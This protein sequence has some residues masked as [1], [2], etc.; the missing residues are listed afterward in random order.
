MIEEHGIRTFHG[1]R[2]WAGLLVSFAFI[3]LLGWGLIQAMQAYLARL[4]QIARLSPDTAIARAGLSMQILGVVM[5]ALAIGTALYTYRASRKVIDNRQLPPPGT[6]VLGK[7]VVVGG[8]RAVLMGRI[9]Y[10][11]AALLAV[12]GLAAAALIWRFVD[13]MMSGVGPA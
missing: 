4:D 11:L 3:L 6:W 5:G 7:P 12:S 2:V 9:G 10:L 13:L 8:D 1:P